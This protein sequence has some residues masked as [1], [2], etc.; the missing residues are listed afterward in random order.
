MFNLP[1]KDQ[2]DKLPN[3]N[4]SF[5]W[6]L[7]KNKLPENDHLFITKTK[8]E[9]ISPCFNETKKIE[10]PELYKKEGFFYISLNAQWDENSQFEYYIPLNFLPPFHPIHFRLK[11]NINLKTILTFSLTLFNLYQKSFNDDLIEIAF[12]NLKI[13]PFMCFKSPLTFCITNES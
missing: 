7:F 12:K 13:Q 5:G 2:D 9:S 11:K 10:I 6:T 8:N 3:S 1:F 4:V